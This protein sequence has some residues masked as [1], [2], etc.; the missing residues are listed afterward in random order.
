MSSARARAE[1]A[2]RERALDAVARTRALGLHFYGHFLGVSALPTAPGRSR[3][4]LDVEPVAGTPGPVPPVA[5][6]SLADL[7]LGAAIRA[8]LGP[9]RRLATTSLAVHHLEP[10]V[11]G[12]VTAEGVALRIEPAHERGFAQCE[13]YAAGG[14]VVGTV[15]GWFV[16]L[17]APPG[18]SLPPVPWERADLPPVPAVTLQELDVDERAAVDASTRAGARAE[19]SATS[20]MEELLGISWTRQAGAAA[21]G[22][23]AVG[24]EHSNRVGHV[25][26]GLVYGAA[27]LAA[28]QATGAGMHL[29]EGHLQFLRPADGSLLVI[30]A[31]EL[32]RGRRA[33]FAEARLFLADRLVASGEFAFHRASERPASQRALEEGVR[34]R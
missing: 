11:F 16:A 4:L 26:G 32:R 15:G 31:R 34:T 12:P 17:P 29:A 21:H 8:R 30:E 33:S 22:E 14:Q 7:A 5:L 6:A 3:L 1:A 10:T 24:P 2:A 20:V 13:L 27:A 28:G 9:N 19:A 23:L 18:R 25:Q